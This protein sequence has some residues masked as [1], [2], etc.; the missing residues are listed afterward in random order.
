MNALLNNRKE[1]PAVKETEPRVGIFWTWKG[2]LFH[3]ESAPVSKAVETKISID[4]AVGHYA[5]WFIME[6]KGILNKLPPF[7]REEYDSIPR[8]R[9]V[10]LKKK[11]SFVV[12]H[13]DDFTRD[14]FETVVKLFNLSGRSIIDEIDEH[15]NPLPE[16]FLF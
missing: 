2:Q 8:G 14:I 1:N 11:K 12:Y 6:K 16:D 15:Y 7:L 13:G 10:Y 4:Y 9:V 5:A 3:A